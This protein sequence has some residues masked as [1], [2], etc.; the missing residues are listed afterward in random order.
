MM[1]KQK[2]THNF[3]NHIKQ[4]LVLKK[5]L[6]SFFLVL[7]GFSN[8]WAE[9]SIQNDQQYIGDDGALHIVGEIQ[10][11][12]NAPIN[13]LEI[14]VTMFSNGEIIDTQKTDSLVNTVMP[15]MKAPFDLIIIGE[16]AKKVDNY[17]LETNFKI[18]EPKSQ[19]IEIT[20]SDF[21]RDDFNNLVISGMVANRGEFT[22]NTI[23]VVATLYD[24]QGNVATV[25]KILT[26][27]D[28]LKADDETF[29]VVGIPDK[30]QASTAVDYSLVA[31]SEEFAAVPEFPLGSS[32]LLA[33]S[34]FFYIVLTRYSSKIITNLVA[35]SNLK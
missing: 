9:I 2:L 13:Q 12:F 34:V 28:Y 11:G 26:E 7:F 6:I 31:E 21:F 1:R 30:L 16:L 17:S 19:V 3:F 4:V 24:R 33:S 18:A 25:S 5:Y 10:N 8:A 27:P 22:A 35:A 20:S 15:G 23:A 32:I 14:L 29:F